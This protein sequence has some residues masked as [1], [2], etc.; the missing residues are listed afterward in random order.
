MKMQL[1]NAVVKNIAK[2]IRNDH[3]K[4]A[5]GGVLDNIAIFTS[6]NAAMLIKAEVNDDFINYLRQVKQPASDYQVLNELLTSMHKY[7]IN[8]ITYDDFE[9]VKHQGKELIS[10]NDLLFD[11]K[12][13]TKFHSSKKF[14]F[15]VWQYGSQH[16]VIVD[17]Y[18]YED[19]M[20]EPCALI[21]GVRN[22]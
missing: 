18:I 1:T 22:L 13:F 17:E 3:F 8:E 14:D 15:R 10:F 16:G 11:P 21:L 9:H 19:D 7:V 20:F 5:I 12:L 2:D 4:Y 6:N